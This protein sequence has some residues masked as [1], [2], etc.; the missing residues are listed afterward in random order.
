M[1]EA[2]DPYHLPRGKE[3]GSI[4]DGRTPTIISDYFEVEAMKRDAPKEEWA[5][6]TKQQFAMLG[7]IMQSPILRP[8]FFKAVDKHLEEMR[9]KNGK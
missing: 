8:E 1:K 9:R 6:Y 3:L 7:V 5:D 2:F 4:R